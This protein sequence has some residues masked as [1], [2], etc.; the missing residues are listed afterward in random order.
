MVSCSHDLTIFSNMV[1]IAVTS[2]YYKRKC[3]VCNLEEELPRAGKIWSGY[4][5]EA[6][7]IRDFD[8]RE[9]AKDLLQPKDEKGE[10]SELFDDAYGNPYKQAEVGTQ[11]DR[12][13]IKDEKRN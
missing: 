12:Y 8:R 1:T 11:V 2:E 9:Y 5:I 10:V 6:E 7:S 3:S 4:S 13:R